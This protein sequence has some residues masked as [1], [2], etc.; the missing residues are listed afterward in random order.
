MPLTQHLLMSY[1]IM[2][3]IPEASWESQPAPAYG[4][5][6][7]GRTKPSKIGVAGL[8]VYFAL[9]HASLDFGLSPPLLTA[10]TW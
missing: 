8:L 6:W 4:E 5:G 2:A 1:A 3:T 10:V 7:H 9:A